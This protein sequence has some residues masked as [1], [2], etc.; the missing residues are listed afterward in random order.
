ME[1]IYHKAAL[2]YKKR[3]GGASALCFDVPKKINLKK[4]LWTIRD[5]AVTCPKCKI[6]I[7]DKR[8]NDYALHPKPIT[9]LAI[10]ISEEQS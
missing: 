3:S 5:E 4:E 6:C 10:P 7:E 1:K 9:Y 2:F 8:P